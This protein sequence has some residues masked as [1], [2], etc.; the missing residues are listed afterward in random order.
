MSLPHSEGVARALR[1]AEEEARTLGHDH[2]GTEHVLLG[3][4]RE[5]TGPAADIFGR[6]QVVSPRVRLEVAK[7]L[8]P[9]PKVPA[10]G[11]PATTP[12]LA[13][14]LEYAAEEA[15]HFGQDAVDTDHLLL[16]LLRE[17]DGVAAHVLADLGMTVSAVRGLV[18][19]L[20]GCEYK[21]WQVQADP[22]SV[23]A[24]ARPVVPPVPAVVVPLPGPKQRRLPPADPWISDRFRELEH[25]LW[26]QQVFLGGLGG[27]LAGVALALSWPWVQDVG[28][29]GCGFAG[30][31]LGSLV[32]AS[33]RAWLGGVVWAVLGVLLGRFAPDVPW[34]LVIGPALGG[35]AGVFVG[36]NL[37]RTRRPL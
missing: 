6:L 1:R 10:S 26:E 17:Q 37:T 8:T 19:E 14:A 9:P 7:A 4:A 11:R 12:G 21:G 18:S 36:L 33:G 5:E 29:A 24:S 25:T 31:L 13:R 22:P 3:L 15:R 32:S 35:L 34:N 2:L 30:L 23:P 16:G 20:R 27:A 28:T